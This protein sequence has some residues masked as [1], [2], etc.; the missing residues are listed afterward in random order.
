MTGRMNLFDAL[1]CMIVVVLTSA[2][3]FVFICYLVAGGFLAWRRPA[4]I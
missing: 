4:S 1:P 2:V 3:H